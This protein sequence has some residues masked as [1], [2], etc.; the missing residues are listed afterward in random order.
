MQG[1]DKDELT[2]KM[3]LMTVKGHVK[4]MQECIDV[5]ADINGQLSKNIKL[6]EEK[7]LYKGATA[8][9]VAAG[10]GKEN[11]LKRLLKEGA[12]PHLVN[13]FESYPLTLAAYYGESGG[14]SGGI[15]LRCVDLL[16]K[17]G[18][19]VNA[20]HN[21]GSSALSSVC[22]EFTAQHMDVVRRLIDEGA[23]INY[24]SRHGWTPLMKALNSV[25]SEGLILI[26]FLLERGA[27]PLMERG[28][29]SVIDMA[30]SKSHEHF[31]EAAKLM[32]SF[33]ENKVLGV[34]IKETG[35]EQSML[36]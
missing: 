33:A 4:K 18:A 30:L 15:A 1:L 21:G 29:K 8:L 9:T 5:G 12:D 7:T 24:Q 13:G 19:D 2:D 16:I 23:N 26:K 36:F 27:D 17:H 14:K 28:G 22:N 34:T 25:D 35:E 32:Q 10:N 20:V 3:I 31:L 6:S 11:C